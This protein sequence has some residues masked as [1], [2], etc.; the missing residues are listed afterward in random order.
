M[1]LLGNSVCF[2][3]G[4]FAAGQ[5]NYNER[6]A[7]FGECMRKVAFTLRRDVLAADYVFWCGDFNYRIDM[8]DPEVKAH[9]EK[10]EWVP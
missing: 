10:K 5:S 6:N 7:D 1:Q 9:I 4:H 8:P 3:C 2:L